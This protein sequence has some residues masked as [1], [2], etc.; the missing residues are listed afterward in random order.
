MVKYVKRDKQNILI[1]MADQLTA[2]ALGCYGNKDV[3]SP[4]IDRLAAEGVLFESAYSSSPLC[5]PAR[6]AFMTGQNI[7]QCGGYDN[8]AYMPATMPTFAHY[9]RLMGYKTCLSGKMHFVGADQLHG[10]EDRVTTDIYPA[11]FGWIPDWNNPD[12]RIDLWYHNMSSVKQAGVASITNQLAYDDEVGAQA[13]R[14]IFDHARSEDERPLCLVTSFIH[15]H[16]P[17]ATRQKYWDL[18]DDVDI[19]PPSVPRPAEQDAHS[20]RLE[21]VIDLDAVECQR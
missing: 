10:F 12:E 1:V 2:L 20:K 5:T 15:P 18:Y 8:A 6:Y 21:K 17:Y 13:M 11:D 3:K 16:D 4:H 14:V 7:S 9:M 19:S